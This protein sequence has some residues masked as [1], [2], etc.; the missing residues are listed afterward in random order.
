MH[1][2]VY[3]LLSQRHG[4]RLKTL[5]RAADQR[6]ALLRALTTSVL[7]YGKIR[8]TILKAKESR[9]WVDKMIGLAKRGDLHAR[10]QALGFIYDKQLVQNLFL[11]A[12]ERYANRTSGFC[13]VKRDEE[14]P[15][16]RGDHA[17]MAYL[18][19]V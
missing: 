4:D 14:S 7:R 16:R 2:L 3:R 9:R 6:K 19:L 18:E 11:V 8:T 15:F 5:G 10:R 1:A 12:P 13:R 17:K